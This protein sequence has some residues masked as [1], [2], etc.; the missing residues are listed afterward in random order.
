MGAARVR[1]NII[2]IKLVYAGLNQGP[3]AKDHNLCRRQKTTTL[4]G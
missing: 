1:R 3:E 2:R 4:R